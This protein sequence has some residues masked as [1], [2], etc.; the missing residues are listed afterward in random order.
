MDIAKRRT[1]YRHIK[2][3]DPKEE[4]VKIDI[5]RKEIRYSN[6]IKQHR[7]IRELGDEEFC[8]AHCIVKLI[9][10]LKYSPD[11]LEL[12]KTHTIGRKEKKTSA[13]IDVLVK[14]KDK[15][16]S[17]FMIIEVKSPET[18]DKDVNQIKTQLFQVAKLE[19][20][21]QY[22]V[23]YT[24]EVVEQEIKERVISVSFGVYDSYNNWE[25]EGK[26]NLYEIPKEYG[27]VKKPIFTKGGIPDLRYDV[28][29]EE[30]ETIRKDLHNVLWG[31]G[32]YHGNEIF[33][34][35]MK[36]FLA[37]IYDEKETANKKAYQFQVYYEN[38]N[39]EPTIKIYERINTLYKDALKR[40]LKLPEKEVKDRDIRKIG[41]KKLDYG[42]IKFVVNTFQDMSLTK[43]I[44]DILGDFFERFLWSE[45]KQ[46][47]G[48]FF[49]HPNIV[50]FIIQALDLEDLILD[51]INKEAELTK[52]I[53]PA[54]GSGTFLIEIMKIITDMIIKN[55]SRFKDTATVKEFL[56]KAVRPY[57]RYAW[58]EDYI[59]GLDYNEDLAM[60][61]KINMIMH[62]DG[63]GNIE[64]ENALESF[65]KFKNSF[66]R[67][68]DKS[69]VYNK[70]V[71]E[72]FDVI[73]TN[74]PF[75]IKLE[76][77]DKEKLPKSFIYATKG[78]SENLFIERWYQLL[79]EGGRFGVV[80]PE[81]VFD[82]PENEYIRLFLFK[83]FWIKAVISLPYLAFQPY[84]STKTSLLF[85]Q[86]KK[87]E[88]IKEYE[89]LW[90]KYAE[91]YDK[92]LKDILKLFKQKDKSLDE[93]ETK[94]N[95]I[96]LLKI[97][98]RQEFKS[99]DIKLS[100]EELKEKYAIYLNKKSDFFV[101]LNWWV[102]SQVSKELDYNIFMADVKNIG[103]KRTTRWEKERP[104][105][106]Y[107]FKEKDGKKEYIVDLDNPKTVLDN[108]RK[109]IKWG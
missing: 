98:I 5:E 108:M 83:Y 15:S 38:G 57:K 2:R 49:T 29:R 23:Y 17:T 11:C 37:K 7:K 104:N 59:F 85:A 68:N 6:K 33:N 101:N 81:S 47:K 42:K 92:L 78:N 66:L 20:G 62:G 30:L 3:L 61:S 56:E 41:D 25:K 19:K 73:I 45:F 10:Q 44:Y 18:Y 90:D 80:L 21:T 102:F 82:T 52:I 51:K 76:K 46:S 79:K 14:N 22:L 70:P 75:S 71:N 36:M 16:Y 26:P 34:F 99:E 87:E 32:R 109:E 65:D 8:R 9:T 107:L 74:P 43:N 89:G 97:L 24:A 103:Y 91:K 95:F 72:Q 64:S 88:D 48:Q 50:N 86:K 12:E 100:L 67:K 58:A 35:I 40:Y 4:F 55:K 77:G 106:L 54:C 1:L 28:K 69:T 27:L 31:G 84:T 105:D 39:T 96:K 63:S 53:D 93:K 60:A 13:R 94:S